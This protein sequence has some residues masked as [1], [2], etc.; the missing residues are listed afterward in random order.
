MILANEAVAG[1]LAGRR[2]EALFRVHEPPDP[3]SVRG[4]LAKLASLEVPTP[5][6]PDADRM[7]PQQ[8]AQLAGRGE[9]ARERVRRAGRS[10][11]A[12]RSRRSSSARSSRRATTRATSAT[13][14]SRAPRT[15]TSRRR[16]AAT[17]T[18]SST[19]RS[20][21]SSAR[22]TIRRPKTSRRRPTT[23]RPA[24]APAAE[25]EY[26]ADD[27]CLAWLLDD[28]LFERGWDDPFGGEI[29][30]LI[31]SGLFVRFGDVFEGF[32]PARRLHGD[33]YEID[34]LETRLVG[35]RGG[36]VFK[37]GDPIDVRV[38]EIRKTEGKG[39]ALA[40]PS[41]LGSPRADADR[42][43]HGARVSAGSATSIRA[44]ASS[45]SGRATRCSQACRCTGWRAGPAASRSSSR[46]RTGARFVD[47]DGHEYVD[48][49]PRRHGRDDRPR[50]RADG[51]GDRPPGAARDHAD[52]P[53]RGRAVGR[54]G[55]RAALRARRLAVRADGDRREP[56]RD[57]ARARGDRA[58]EG[59][60]LQLVLPRHRR[61]DVR[62]AARTAASSRARAT[63]ARPSRSTRPRASSS[64]TTSRRSSASSPTATSPAC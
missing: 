45:L 26:R 54:R 5:P 12:R 8:A 30:G 50:A 19:G 60:R 20:C 34:A 27:I 52:A 51:R 42:R 33:F 9:R 10:A 44:R 62:R 53:D 61:R 56:L 25:V 58:A 55:A 2:R 4:L 35:R 22:A 1:L 6:V 37:L 13:R 28:V 16:S 11:A 7:A 21:A 57:P 39:R 24:S 46:R 43:A 41:A 14:A 36:G 18:S 38:E 23:A 63:S 40:R 32:L 17:P 15:A 3:Q 64:S 49:L 59:A 47:V 31:G 29:T 48:L